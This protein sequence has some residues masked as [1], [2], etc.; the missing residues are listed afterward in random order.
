MNANPSQADFV[1]DYF[2][3]RANEALEYDDWTDALEAEYWALTGYR[4]RF[5]RSVARRLSGEGKLRKVRNGVYVYDGGLA[6]ASQPVFSE[7]ALN[8]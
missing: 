6:Q 5:F 2:K 1:L 4:A 8:A 7:S 3:S